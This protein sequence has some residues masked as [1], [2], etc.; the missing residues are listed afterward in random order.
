MSQEEICKTIKRKSIIR[1]ILVEKIEKNK[2]ISIN[3]DDIN[4]KISKR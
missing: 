3:K 4:N 1:L 2:E